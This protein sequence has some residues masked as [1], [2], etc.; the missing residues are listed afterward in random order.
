M[1]YLVLDV[2]TTTSNKGNPFDETNKLCYI[3]VDRHCYPIEFTDSPYGDSLHAVQS[4]I[5]NADLLVGFNIKFDLHW[6]RKL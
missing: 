4:S 3:G 6:I 5:N 1:T 2:E